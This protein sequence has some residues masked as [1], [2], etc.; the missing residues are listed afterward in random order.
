LSGV[1]L[2]IV[3]QKVQKA[4]QSQDPKLEPLPVPCPAGLPPGH[5]ARNHD[6]SKKG[7]WVSG[8]GARDCLIAALN[9]PRPTR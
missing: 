3:S 4:V 8:L 9:A 5:A 2:V 7:A 1:A 6:I